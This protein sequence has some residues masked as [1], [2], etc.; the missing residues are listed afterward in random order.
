MLDAIN[1][2]NRREVFWDEYLI[3]KANTTAELVLHEPQVKEVVVNH[4]EPWEGDGCDFHNIVDDD[5]LYRMYYL[6]WETMDPDVTEHKPRPIVVCYAESRDGIVWEKPHLNICEFEG[7]TKN[8]IILD[9]ETA[10]YDNFFVFIDKNPQCPDSER[11]KGVGLDGNDHYLWCFTSSD[12]IHFT[13]SWRITN[14]G[15]FDTLNTAL[16]DKH[17][18]RYFCYI[19]DFHDV[20]ADGNLNEG[21]R[22]VRWLVSDDFKNWSTPVLLDFGE[23][24]D[25]PIYTNVVQQYYRADHMFIGFPSR[26]VEKK[27]WTRD[28][29]QLAGAEMRKKR[30]Q[31]HPRYGLTV[32]DCVFMSS[33]DGAVWD[34]WDEAFL[35]PG[36]E[37]HF[38]W[39][40][41]DCYPAW[42]LV[43]TKSSLPHAPNELSMY[44]YDNHW[45]MNPTHLRRYT[46]RIDGFVSLRAKYQ[47]A[48]AVLKP[49]IFNG[50]KLSINF[51]TS[52]AGSVRIQLRGGGQVINSV[53]M[54]GDSLDRTVAFKDSDV[55]SLA[56]MPVE[57]EITMRD[58][59]IYSFRFEN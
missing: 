56:G 54:I 20:P 4:D 32:T 31:V 24:D 40:Y 44:T 52:A 1:I 3:D 55:A 35:R 22:D 33:R 45:S 18:G 7:S 50:Q 25:Y 6:G 49:V 58:A 17:S 8:N 5:G 27:E 16:W 9:S 28:F 23:G 21:V 14:Q 11:Y 38:N 53:E 26:Y 36:P 47:P 51:A 13:K 10:K 30:M 57:M 19:R 48:R 41:G 42:G 39:V 2:G 15:K 46:I 34:R 59:D 37:R 29:D 12:G 43:E